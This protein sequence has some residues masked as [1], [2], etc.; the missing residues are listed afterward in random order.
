MLKTTNLLLLFL[1]LAT[2]ACSKK[3][4]D[5]RLEVSHNFVFGSAG[6][7]ELA[8]GG[9]MVWGTSSTGAAFGRVVGDGSAVNLQ[10]QSGSW[11]F[12]AMAWDGT[13]NYFNTTL[14]PGDR[15][16]FGGIVRCGRSAP[17][18]IEGE[19][20]TVNLTLTDV[21]CGDQAFKGTAA[22]TP[23]TLRPF[24]P[25]FCNSVT[26]VT[27]ATKVCADTIGEPRKVAERAPIGSFRIVLKNFFTTGGPRVPGPD[28]LRGE[29]V[30]FFG[31]ADGGVEADPYY[32]LSKRTVPNLPA[33]GPGLPFFTEI[34]MFPGNGDCNAAGINA[35]APILK[36]FPDGIANNTFNSKNFVTAAENRHYLTVPPTTVCAGREDPSPD[37]AAFAAGDGSVDRPYAI[38]NVTQWNAISDLTKAYK[39]QANLNFNPFSKGIGMGMPTSHPLYHCLD[40]GTNFVPLGAIASCA[41]PESDLVWNTSTPFT[42]FL[43]GGSFTLK[44]LRFRNDVANDVGL[45]SQIAGNARIQNL[46][47]DSLELEGKSFV[48]GLAGSIAGTSTPPAIVK[49]DNIQIINSEVRARQVSGNSKAGGLAG[50]IAYATVGNIWIDRSRLKADG[51][52]VG[53]IAGD[54]TNST[55]RNISADM[56]IRADFQ[57]VQKIGGIFGLT[58]STSIDNAKFEGSITA[59]GDMIGGI[60]GVA[61]TGTQARN[62]Y[63]IAFIRNSSTGSNLKTGG[64][65]G[66]WNSTANVGP[67]YSLSYLSSPCMTGCQLGAIVGM[68]NP[69]TWTLVTSGKLYK[70]SATETGENSGGTFGSQEMV[71]TLDQFKAP[72][73]SIGGNFPNT[74]I[75][76]W[77][78]KTSV[79]PRLDFENHVCTGSSVQTSVAT[80]LTAK[81]ICNDNEYLAMESDTGTFFKLA[82]NIRLPNPTSAATRIATFSKQLDGDH[83]ALIGGIG[84]DVGHI[85]TNNGT[86]KN[87]RLL[88]LTR[89][90]TTAGTETNPG[91]VF[92]AINN[93]N[94]EDIT[95]DLYGNFHSYAGLLVGKNAVNLGKIR[96]VEVQ[97]ALAAGGSVAPIAYLNEGLIEGSISSTE[98]RSNTATGSIYA[99]FVVKNQGTIIRSNSKS[100]LHDSATQTASEV[101]MLVY[102]NEG[103]IQDVSVSD[104]SYYSIHGTNAYYFYK[105]NTTGLGR[106]D[107]LTN[108]GSIFR[109][110]ANYTTAIT[111]FPT[112]NGASEGTIGVLLRQGGRSGIRLLDRQPF[113]CTNADDNELEIPSWSSI[114][115][116]ANWDSALGLGGA[117]N[118]FSPNAKRLVVDAE[119]NSGIRFIQQ[120]I[121]F[122]SI[123]KKFS[124]PSEDCPDSKTGKVSLYWT[125][126]IPVGSSGVAAA[127]VL[128]PQDSLSASNAGEE[129]Y[130]NTYI[131]PNDDSEVLAYYAYYLGIT[132][133]AVT[134]RL[135]EYNDEGL[136]LFEMK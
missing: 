92:V 133:T 72:A 41:G 33:G 60:I 123:A 15:D 126:D 23:G 4:S 131:L 68:T 102:N 101:S 16:V 135:W 78:Y 47:L 53:G 120:V 57:G 83:F 59:T 55:V 91:A 80:Q 99:G 73:T 69:A 110:P 100:R 128:L 124:I 97:G 71:L 96:N 11:T 103:I 42:G 3:S 32:G 7:S 34:E 10:L 98:M 20:A 25:V 81:R 12:F 13:K 121:N 62:V 39:L 82:A 52:Y 118:G 88:G 112:D 79:Y 115:D 36:A 87:L 66:F 117:Y 70:L 90:D 61:N 8:K 86:L 136:E 38:C 89:N 30:P 1:A 22:F 93:G 129:W 28:G 95:A 58:S 6:T 106:I 76:D 5:V 19:R 29:C 54:A 84:Q 130:Y 40:F 125:N 31:H 65:F 51:K 111:T 109:N 9:L 56:E 122:D 77:E 48:G 21:G 35:R 49:V 116:F 50:S 119:L 14:S 2:V 108:F 132:S 43:E 85:G 17:T 24:R 45:F 37:G 104:E 105:T 46:K 64:L 74:G 113:T 26:N 18:Q 44:G 134:P 127:G 114:P 107:R 94:L 63:S 75:N 27:D 67:G